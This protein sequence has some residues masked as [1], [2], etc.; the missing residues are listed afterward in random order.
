MS[1][2]S[3]RPAS[4]EL[5]LLPLR[6]MTLLPGIGQPVELGR[7][8]S[9]DAIR[10]AREVPKDDPRHRL[11][12]V[13]TQREE[14]VDRP[15]LDDLYP[16]GV[17]AEITQAL[18]G[19]G[20]RMTAI[21]RGIERVHVLEVDRQ[22]T[23]SM[24]RYQR[25]HEPTGDPTL[26]YALAG[27]LQDLVRQ[28]DG[29]LPAN[30]QSKQRA[31]TLAVINAERAPSRIADLCATHVGLDSVELAELLHELTITDRLRKVVE[32]VSHR[33]HVL[34][35]KRDLDRHVRDHLS[36]H[37]QEAL[38]RHKLRAI[39]SELGDPD[40]DGLAELEARLDEAD[41][42]PDAR[43]T[44][45]RE[46]GRL[47][48]MNPQSGE[49]TIVRT[50]LEL[51]VELP[52][53]DDTATPDS[54]D[55]PAA[56]E[57]LEREHFGLEK[58]KQRIIEYLCV[59]KLAPNKRGP[60]LCL[61]GPPG[62]G[63]TSLARSIAQTLGREFVRISL[64]GVRDDAEIRG[65]RRTYVGSLPGRL[66]HG[67]KRAGTKNPVFLLD[68]IDKLGGPDLRGDPAGALLEALDP[69][70]NDAFEDHYLGT[71][72]D[73]SRVIF[74]TTANDLQRIPH[75]LRDRLEIIEL[76]GYTIEDKIAIARDYLLPRALEDHGLAPDSL[77]VPD[78]VLSSLATEYTRE[79][80]VRNLQRELEA[81]LRDLAMEIAQGEPTRARLERADLLRVLG[82]PKYH[83]DLLDHTPSPGVVN[84]LGWTP[85]GGRLLIVE[86]TLTLGDGKLRLTGRLGE[87]MKESAQ[88]AMS[89]VRSEA[90]RLGLDPDFA[91]THDVHVH[92]PAGA[93]PKDG[94]SAGIT[95]TTALVSVLTRR[96]A[97]T[98]IAMT[99]EVTLHGHVL[100]IGGVREKVLAAHRAGIRDIILPRRNAKDEPDIP[101]RVLDDLRLH[102]VDRVEEV[103]ELVLLEPLPADPADPEDPEQAAAQ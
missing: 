74:V 81:M 85:T 29:L 51:V 88:T 16:V 41:L 96:P 35:V 60:I 21:V 102:Y 34:Q 28:H 49:A 36:K 87:V 37:E 1:G 50:Y 103:L 68:E 30:A 13:V 38:L 95:L 89:L 94:P 27:T 82:P 90:G 69:E 23:P 32:L 17:L 72:F 44:V 15:G 97:R 65:H 40:D 26:A 79:S 73:L 56:R 80:G 47:R 100:A 20:S 58:V 52:W 63:K 45:D 98:D 76:S 2:R 66:I 19:V 67:M 99:G 59:R 33:I 24:V 31:Q 92:L 53:S 93:V 86:A 62:V 43:A 46:L 42:P 18:L 91:S 12:V 14:S 11:V 10:M 78:E 101:K 61:A 55:I 22:Q 75:V 48:R 4:G 70:Q 25:A 57:L 54:L 39:Q 7:H 83:D 84:G 64:G 8:A 3:R 5:P 77:E 71:P 6:N 9:V